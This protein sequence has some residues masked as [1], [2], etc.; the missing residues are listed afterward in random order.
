[1]LL[2]GV[3]DSWHSF[4]L[5]LPHLPPSL[6]VFALTQRGHGDASRPE[7]G[8]THLD[9]A[10]DLAAFMDILHIEKA[11]LAGHS[12]GANVAKRFAIDHPSCVSGLILIGS[13]G[14]MP[15]NPILHDIWDTLI[16]KLMDP[17]DPGFVREFQESV[18]A[19][20]VPRDFFETMV[21]EASKLPARV[22]KAVFESDLQTDLSVEL[23]KIKVPTFLIWGDQDNA[24][25][26]SGRELQKAAIPNSRLEIYEGAGHA[27]HWEKPERIAAD[28]ADFIENNIK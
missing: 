7:S 22:W 28:I 19:H 25:S 15:N 16:S 12:M 2:H 4:E 23:A 9:F 3:G 5:V 11:V 20:P 14:S 18:I 17:V 1:M 10:E 26:R 27:V 24:I 6:H 8:Y 21:R 13:F